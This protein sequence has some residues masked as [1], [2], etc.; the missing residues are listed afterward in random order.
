MARTEADS[1][2][3]LELKFLRKLIG[4]S[5]RCDSI[6]ALKPNS[7]TSLAKCDRICKSLAD[8]GL[9]TY[10]SK[11]FRF[12]ISAPGRMLLSLQTTSLPVTPDELKLLKVCRGSM[13][14]EKLGGCVP[15]EG[16]S[17]LISQL[18]DRKLLKVTKQAIVNV[19]LTE[20]GKAM[21]CDRYHDLSNPVSA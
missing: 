5:G 1:L 8:K 9:V 7:R 3:P 10:E 2:D 17:Q 19:R 4:M 6:A 21:L 12:T 14:A 15:V 13:T 18:V 11:I 20:K 16:R